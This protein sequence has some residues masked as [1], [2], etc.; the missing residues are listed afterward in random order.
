MIHFLKILANY[1]QRNVSAHVNTLPIPLHVQLTVKLLSFFCTCVQFVQSTQLSTETFSSTSAVSEKSQ[2]T[3]S[4]QTP[5]CC[6]GFG[7]VGRSSLNSSSSLSLLQPPACHCSSSSEESTSQA[8]S[9]PSCPSRQGGMSGMASL[10]T[11]FLQIS[12]GR[13]WSS[14]I[15]RSSP[16]SCLCVSLRAAS[17]T[18]AQPPQLL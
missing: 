5:T 7:A 18:W 10:V 14:Q 15:R 3:K 13:K 1:Y 2:L 6:C 4:E 12:S 17:Q 11:P 9:R 16:V 8:L